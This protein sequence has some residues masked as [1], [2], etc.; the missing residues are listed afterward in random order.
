MTGYEHFQQLPKKDVATKTSNPYITLY[1]YAINTIAYSHFFLLILVFFMLPPRKSRRSA[2]LYEALRRAQESNEGP[3]FPPE[4]SAGEGRRW[5]VGVPTRF[6]E[7]G[8]L[9][10][11][12]TRRP[13]DRCKNMK[14][15]KHMKELWFLL[16]SITKIGCK[17]C[18]CNKNHNQNSLAIATAEATK[19]FE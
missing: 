2:P 5:V 1:F 11:E 4:R 7:F 12:G 17:K 16:V 10:S 3:G 8:D 13:K 15:T 18:H 19:V 9:G 6:A 14:H